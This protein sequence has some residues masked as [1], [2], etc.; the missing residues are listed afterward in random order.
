MESKGMKGDEEDR[1]EFG[2]Q[3][4]I[5][6]TVTSVL[7]EKVRVVRVGE[8]SGGERRRWFEVWI[9]NASK[10]SSLSRGM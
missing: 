9:R 5:A 3:F 6:V 10:G 8:E 2:G 1:K 4:Q 7:F